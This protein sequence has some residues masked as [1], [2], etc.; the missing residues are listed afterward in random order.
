MPRQSS[1]GWFLQYP[2][3]KAS[4]RLLISLPGP[5]MGDISKSAD[6]QNISAAEL[7][8]RAA[9]F[10]MKELT[11]AHPELELQGKGP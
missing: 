6:A 4:T 2:T 1:E 8:R 3:A 10:H 7:M 5:M 9:T 11:R